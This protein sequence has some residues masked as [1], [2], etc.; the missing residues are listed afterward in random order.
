MKVSSSLKQLIFVSIYTHTQT[1]T[2]TN[3]ARSRGIY[4]NPPLLLII[5]TSVRWTVVKLPSGFSLANS[6]YGSDLPKKSCIHCWWKNSCLEI[7][8]TKKWWPNERDFLGSQDQSLP[9]FSPNYMHVCKSHSLYPFPSTVKALDFKH[10]LYW[11][12]LKLMTLLK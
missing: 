8:E 1:D 7:F 11:L 10:S 2:H 4:Y 3:H 6:R 12:T 5:V 9:S